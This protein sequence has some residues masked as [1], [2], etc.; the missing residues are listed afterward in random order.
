VTPSPHDHPDDLLGP[1]A[2]GLLTAVEQAALDDHLRTC[3]QCRDELVALEGV[4]ARLGDLDPSTALLDVAGSPL[5]AE[6]VLAAVADERLQSR[7]RA[8]RLQSVLA[9]AAAAAVLV[10]GLVTAAALDPAPAG[11]PV[12]AVA[13]TAAADLDV[14][15]GLVAHTWGM[16][17]KLAAAGFSPGASYDVQVR[18]TA[19]EL[20]DAGAFLGT[21]AKV[22]TCSLSSAVLR[23]DAAAFVVRDAA[24]TEVLSAS[25]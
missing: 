14:T 11:A 12:E 1:A 16:E 2:L 21:G 6:A 22:L 18:T 24:G 5:R 13:V 25:F 10:A 3:A 9:G 20:V 4:T 15:A 17:I 23:E 19:G 7:R 8:R